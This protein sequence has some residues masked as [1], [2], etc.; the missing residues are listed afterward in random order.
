[1]KPGL[2]RSSRA[3]KRYQRLSGEGPLNCHICGS[4]DLRPA[5]HLR[6]FA[7]V[8]CG[9]CGHGLT[10]H[11]TPPADTQE[12]FQGN[13]WIETRG[14]LEAATSAMARLRYTE[15][16]EFRPGHELLEVGCGTGEFLAAA[17]SAGHQVVG[18]DLSR[19]A[20]DYVRERH[21]GL[22]VRCE[23]LDSP[24]L[25]PES[26]DVVAAFHVLEHVPDP[27]GLLKQMHELLRPGGLIYIRVPNLDTW[28]RRVLGP[29][30]WGFSV[31]H[32]AHFTSDSISMALAAASLD[33]LAVRSADSDPA[34]SL[35]PVL[36]LLLG[37]SAALRSL[38]NALQPPRTPNRPFPMKEKARLTLKRHIIG[39]YLGY[40]RS[41][42]VA[43]VP[44]TR[45]QLRKGGG[46][47]LMIVG[48]KQAG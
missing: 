12:R 10:I 4:S 33:V 36:P 25:A 46:P 14:L 19:E 8:S 18:L 35:W 3:G 21:P 47:E 32:L 41:A 23:T 1:M 39:A 44:L 15:L 9:T 20:V 24:T 2:I 13:R 30:W 28:Y 37:R 27:I 45:A 48:R 34:N 5:Y 29:N 26:F 43:I 42:T 6:E 22:D 17:Q 31:E 16:K 11:A 38:G 7:V 40:R